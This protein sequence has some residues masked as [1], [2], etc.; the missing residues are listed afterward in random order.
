[1]TENNRLASR[2]VTD[3]GEERKQKSILI[4]RVEFYPHAF[5]PLEEYN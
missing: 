5:T 3:F 1:M 2:G 4:E